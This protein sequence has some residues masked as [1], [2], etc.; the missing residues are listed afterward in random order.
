MEQVHFVLLLKSRCGT[1]SIN[2]FIVRL[3]T[4]KIVDAL[5]FSAPGLSLSCGRDKYAYFSV[6]GKHK[7]TSY[8]L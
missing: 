1:P 4:L 5:R 2:A 3:I 8:K 6:S 7:T